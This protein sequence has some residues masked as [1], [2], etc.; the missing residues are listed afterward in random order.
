M[1]QELRACPS[2]ACLLLK[3]RKVKIVI[4]LESIKSSQCFCYSY[5]WPWLCSFCA[6]VVTLIDS[7]SPTSPK[8][9]IFQNYSK[10]V[11]LL[12]LASM[13]NL[14]LVITN[15]VCYL[16]SANLIMEKKEKTGFPSS[17]T[18]NAL[19]VGKQQHW[20]GPCRSFTSP[21]K[22]AEQLISFTEYAALKWTRNVTDC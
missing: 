11:P 12:L 4:S 20:K 7:I 9:H 10:H 13:K 19:P 22:K 17:S 15:R 2:C 18:D 6:W 21:E 8:L 1:D 14:I 3:K 5:A 16:V